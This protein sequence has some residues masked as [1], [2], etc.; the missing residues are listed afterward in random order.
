MTGTKLAV[1]VLS[2]ATFLGGN[3][4]QRSVDCYV[5]NSPNVLYLMAQYKMAVG[6]TAAGLRLLKQAS[7]PVKTQETQKSE[8]RI[9]T[10]SKPCPDTS[11]S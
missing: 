4:L 9:N 8:S 11:R 7:A 1:T 6:D 5:S 10:A 2:L 3:Q